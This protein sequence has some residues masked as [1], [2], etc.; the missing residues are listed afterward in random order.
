MVICYFGDSESIHLKKWATHFK[1]L[2]HEV[3]VI[4]FKNT[5]IEGIPHHHIDAGEIQQKGG[6]FKVL[7]TFRR[8]K[9]ILQQIKPDFLHAHYATSYGITAALTGF[10]PLIISAWGSDVLV[11]PSKSKLLKLLLKFAFRK[12]DRVT[13]VAPHMQMALETLNVP[14][15][16]QRVITHGIKMD[17]FYPM[18]HLRNDDVF[19]IVS[20]RHFEPIYNPFFVLEAFVEFSKRNEKVNLILVGDGSLKE[21]LQAYCLAQSIESKVHFTGKLSQDELAKTLNRSHVF[22]SMSSSD[23]DV[24]SMAEAMACGCYCLGSDIPANRYWIQEPLNGALVPLG[25]L[26]SFV[27]KLQHTYDHYPAL[28]DT[29]QAFNVNLIQQ[30]GNWEFNMNQALNMYQDVVEHH[31]Q[32]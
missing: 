7:F 11:S 24:V 27:Q 8:I 1:E 5:P 28:Q 12:A 21:E 17:V 15:S 30:Q 10:H 25:N 6:N 19:T 23:G 16:K 18:P 31:G 29:A 20:T 9:K 3:H 32:R 14:K 2:G 13:V 22:I 4:S 26:P